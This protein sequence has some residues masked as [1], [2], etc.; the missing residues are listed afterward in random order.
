[1]SFLRLAFQFLDEALA[2]AVETREKATPHM[3][4]A[5]EVVSSFGINHGQV[6]IAR[7]R[8]FVVVRNGVFGDMPIVNAARLATS[9][10]YAAALL[11]IGGE[12]KD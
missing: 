9:K 7:R 11:G 2:D 8:Q 1:M 6:G 12:Q 10:D 5:P 4:T 3:L